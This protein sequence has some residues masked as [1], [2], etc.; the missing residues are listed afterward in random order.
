MNRISRGIISGALGALVSICSACSTG[1]VPS[2][3]PSLGVAPAVV[4]P[5]IASTKAATEIRMAFA[6]D[7]AR[8][9]W[10]VVDSQS[11]D[12]FEIVE[13]VMEE[14][15]WSAGTG[16]SFNSPSNDF[17]PFFAPDGRSVLFFSNRPGGWGGDD[18][19]SVSYDPA[20]RKYGEPVNLGP[21]VN[22]QGNEWAPALSQDGRTLLFSSDGHDGHGG[23]DLFT[24]ALT[25]AGWSVPV[26]LGD[27][28]NSSADDFDATFIGSDTLV[29]TS[30]DAEEGPIF[31]Y[32]A[33]IAE[34][35]FAGREQLQPPFNCSRGFNLGPSWTSIDPR[36]L[37]FSAACP[38]FGR[39]RSDIFV[40]PFEP[41]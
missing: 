16:V 10:G 39:G 41:H 38:E 11:A 8:R 28:V 9:L 14:A 12:G 21:T 6:P 5:D 3:S 24:A 32:L 36:N 37:Y 40:A 7:G 15:G 25:A 34:G 23:Q 22:T 29:Y 27:G 17:D 19:W 1:S 13:S 4:M 33:H 26:N 30:G 2:A 18:L 20:T 35:R 31:L